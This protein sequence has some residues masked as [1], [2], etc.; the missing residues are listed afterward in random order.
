MVRAGRASCRKVVA[1]TFPNCAGL[2]RRNTADNKTAKRH[3]VPDAVIRFSLYTAWCKRGQAKFTV[4]PSS[5]AFTPPNPH[6]KI[7]TTKS[8]YGVHAAKTFLAPCLVPVWA[9]DA[10]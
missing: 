6:T 8:R 4:V 2:T 10:L 3:A 1:A 7:R 9:S 5:N